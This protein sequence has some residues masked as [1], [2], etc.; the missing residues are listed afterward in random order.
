MLEAVTCGASDEILEESIAELGNLFGREWP[1]DFDGVA[2]A[3]LG[4]YAGDV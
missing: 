2:A 3:G 1:G 4:D